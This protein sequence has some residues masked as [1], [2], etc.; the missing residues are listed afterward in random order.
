MIGITSCGY[1]IPFCRLEREKIGQAWARRAGKGERAAIYFD[2]DALT[3][4]LEAAQRCLEERGKSGIDALYFA[5]TSAPFWQRSSASFMAAACDLPAECETMDFAG[6]LRSAT[7]ALR[8]GIDALNSGRLSR[9][10]IAA[11]E[12]R[13]GQPGESEEEW[14]ADAGSAVMLGREGVIAEILGVASRSDDFLDE[15]RRDT[16]GFIQTQ[17]SRFTTERGYQASLVAVGKALLQTH[18]VQPQDCAKII[19]PSPDGRAHVNAAKKL[20]FQD[21][22]IHHPLFQEVGACG[23]A[24]PFL[25]LAAALETAR[26][27]DRLLLLAYGEGADGLLLRVTAEISTRSPSGSLSDHLSEKRLYPSYQIYKKM[28]EYYAENKD[29]A[30]L[31]NVFL[32]KEEKQNVRLY[33][34]HCLRCGTRQYPLARV[35]IA[36]HNHDSLQEVPLEHSGHVFTFTRDH[37]YVAPDSPTI[38]SVVDLNQGGRL[39]IQMT[40]VDPEDV[41]VGDEVVLTL[42]RRKE[43]PTMHHYY[44]KCR[45]VR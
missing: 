19:L 9:V 8:A 44:W 33:G 2:E 30:D 21:A 10:L 20:G 16:D 6:S 23:S 14:F 41:R 3:L 28:R 36:C 34:T 25:L 43:G 45:P 27:G 22:Q 38:M 24:A 32:A 17:S 5:S 31:S 29:G 4:G 40:D 12:V 15:W 26:P 7:S 18:G 39:Y 1:H 42:R 35:C 13:D 37:L 11:G